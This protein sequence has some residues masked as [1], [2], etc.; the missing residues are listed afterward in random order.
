M[1]SSDNLFG[2]IEQWVKNTPSIYVLKEWENAIRRAKNEVLWDLSS[3]H[4]AWANILMKTIKDD[5][6]DSN[7][8]LLK[9]LQNNLSARIEAPVLDNEI[10][11]RD[12]EGIT[13]EELRNI[14]ECERFISNGLP[15]HPFAGD[16]YKDDD[17]YYINIRPDCD[18]I[19][20]K[21]DLYLLKGNVIDEQKI[22][23]QEQDGIVFDSGNFIEKINSC[24]VA[25][26]EGKIIEFKF[27]KMEI[28]K[29][30]DI[31]V[32]RIGRL[33]PPYITRIQQKYS[34][35]LQR[36]GLP[37]LPIQSI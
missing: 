26:V 27:R 37:S 15:N 17:I 3:A 29:W 32:K 21:K 7:S 19:R 11:E 9:L 34:F 14:L 20:E 4:S 23:T 2:E 31:K 13:K 18:I 30:N 24:Y 6:A 12:V 33:L 10:L 25:F 5:G 16:I 28:R 36:Q 8:E 1:E 22:N 35:Y